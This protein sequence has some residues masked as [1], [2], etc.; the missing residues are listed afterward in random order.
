MK[1]VKKLRNVTYT[2]VF[3]TKFNISHHT[4]RLLVTP[5]KVDLWEVMPSSVLK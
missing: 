1:P 2:T 5:D 3:L 4:K